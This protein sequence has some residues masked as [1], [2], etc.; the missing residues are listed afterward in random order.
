MD[1][2]DVNK[3]TGSVIHNDFVTPHRSVSS[4]KEDVVTAG[5]HV[6]ELITLLSNATL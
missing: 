5:I 2:N 6:T 1:M 4:L 3:I